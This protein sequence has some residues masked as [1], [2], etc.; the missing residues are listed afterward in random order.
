MITSD[1]DQLPATDD[2][3]AATARH[4]SS[5][6]VDSQGSCA[7]GLGDWTNKPIRQ[8]AVPHTLAI[9]KNVIP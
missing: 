3:Q 4:F 5:C 6:A 8:L 9:N 1:V 2:V 7:W